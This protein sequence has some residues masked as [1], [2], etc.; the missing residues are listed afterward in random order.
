[1]G[2]RRAK[3]P[4]LRMKIAIFTHST[5]PRGGVVHALE[6]AEALTRLGHHAVLH[7]PDPRNIGFFRQA[8]CD[9]IRIPAAA[10]PRDVY[11]LL[12]QRRQEI[13]RYV[14]E[15]RGDFD[16]FHAQDSISANALADIPG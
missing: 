12:T 2:S 14:V 6:L 9:T 7:A 15:R 1:M 16:V 5:N 3:I 10:A 8:E 13:R 11:G 4:G